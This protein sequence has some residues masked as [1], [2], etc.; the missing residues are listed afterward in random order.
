M[1]SNSNISSKLLRSFA[2]GKGN[3][4]I[5]DNGQFYRKA[6]HTQR[7]N[8]NDQVINS[9]GTETLPTDLRSRL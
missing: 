9:L 4:A 2:D 1:P 5:R 7:K 3:N 6:I 8:I